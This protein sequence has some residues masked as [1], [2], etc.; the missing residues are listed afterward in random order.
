MNKKR[1]GCLAAAFTLAVSMTGVM[2]E[3]SYDAKAAQRDLG[4]TED[5]IRGVDISSVM[6]FE[7]SG[8]KFYYSNG[9]EGDIFDILKDAGVNYIRVRV[10]NDPYDAQTH[11]G[12]GGGN[13]D[14]SKAIAI[15]QRATA[16]GMNLLVDFHYSDFWA[17][18]AK[19]YA[20]KAWKDYTPSYLE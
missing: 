9:T 12:Y 15:G 7:Q 18:P 3:T 2:P 4:I 17:D 1:W 16:H 14:I 5:F 8:R 11:K 10:W 19:Q 6:A 20:P 13:N